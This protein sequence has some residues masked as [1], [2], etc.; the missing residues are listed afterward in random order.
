LAFS[1][2]TVTAV[3]ESLIA[4]L[5]REIYGHDHYATFGAAAASIG[6]DSE[7][8]HDHQHRLA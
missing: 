6:H 4:T 5:N 2:R 1:G 7:R 3:A 8:V